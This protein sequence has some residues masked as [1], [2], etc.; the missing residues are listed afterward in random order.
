MLVFDEALYAKAQILRWKNE[1]YKNRLVIRLGEFHTIMSFCSAI[2]KIFRD[3]GLEVGFYTSSV[4]Q[5]VFLFN[6]LCV[7]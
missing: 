1:E 3:A 5:S 2:A 6:G 4:R 7:C